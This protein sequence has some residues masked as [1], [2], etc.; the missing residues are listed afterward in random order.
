M[1]NLFIYILTTSLCIAQLSD[2]DFTAF[3]DNQAH[4][5]FHY[6]KSWAQVDAS[7][8]ATRFKAVSQD[9]YGR[10]DISINVIPN[11]QAKGKAPEAHFKGIKAN[12]NIVLS[13][14]KNSHP[15]ARIID[16]GETT[17][18]N[19]PAYYIITAY[20]HSAVGNKV[21]IRQLQYITG[22]DGLNYTI[23][24]RSTSGNWEQDF[25]LFQILA[26][27]FVLHPTY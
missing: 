9:G 25:R 23:T 5:S 10:E 11:D 17:L 15:D 18:S 13:L 7:H 6:P 22:R 16:Y 27:R 4:F 8:S 2:A 3:R 19:Q 26:T 24:M 14:L 20:T 21:Y 12:P 1:K